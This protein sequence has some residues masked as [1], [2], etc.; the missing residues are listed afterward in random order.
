M[1]AMPR[2]GTTLFSPRRGYRHLEADAG[3]TSNSTL[4]ARLMELGLG[5]GPKLSGIDVKH[6]RY[7]S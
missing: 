7:E 4:K 2:F 5:V 6:P 3:F 1:D